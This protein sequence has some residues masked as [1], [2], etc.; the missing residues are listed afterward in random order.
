MD[1]IIVLGLIPGTHI[2][3][4]FLMWLIAAVLVIASIVSLYLKRKHIVAFW[5]LAWQLNTTIK[6]QQLA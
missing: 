4:T 5:L 1:S 2:Q 3:I 6:R